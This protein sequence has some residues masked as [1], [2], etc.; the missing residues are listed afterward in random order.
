[1]DQVESLKQ[2]SSQF[3]FTGSLSSVYRVSLL[4]EGLESFNSILCANHLRRQPNTA[5][6]MAHI[7]G[8]HM[9]LTCTSDSA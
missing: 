2:R 1:M 5:Q 3:K 4:L 9:T 7:L 6:L 8:I